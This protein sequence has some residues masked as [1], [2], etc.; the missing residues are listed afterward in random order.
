[1]E[2]EEV[3]MTTLNGLLRYWDSFIRGIC[4]RRKITKFS[5]LWQE[6]VQEKGRLANREEKLNEDEDEDLA[7]HTKNGRNKRKDRGSPPRRS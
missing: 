7:V 5:K 3:V 6:C 1:M 4:A 2:E